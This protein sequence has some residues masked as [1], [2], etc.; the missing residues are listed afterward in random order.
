MNDNFECL[1]EIKEI[2]KILK[3]KPD[4][5]KFKRMGIR[6]K[7]QLLTQ[8]EQLNKRVYLELFRYKLQMY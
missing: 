1:G 5:N 4:H 7:K 2:E 8:K 3:F 6:T